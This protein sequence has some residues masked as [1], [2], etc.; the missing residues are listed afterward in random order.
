MDVD[1]SAGNC[2]VLRVVDRSPSMRP[3]LAQQAR[4]VLLAAEGVGTTEIVRRVGL[5]ERGG[6]IEGVG[7]EAHATRLHSI[8]GE[9]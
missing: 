9:R 2:E 6:T 7:P 8:G 5:S 1:E 3:G 4:V